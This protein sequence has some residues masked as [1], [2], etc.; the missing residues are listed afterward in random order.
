MLHEIKQLNTRKA[1]EDTDIPQKIVKMSTD[2]FTDFLHQN[3]NDA[4]IATS[5]ES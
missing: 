5:A 1:C 4:A 3:F 2:I